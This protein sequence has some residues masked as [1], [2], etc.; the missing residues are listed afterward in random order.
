M[1]LEED[2]CFST[3]KNVLWFISKCL[4]LREQYWSVRL[5]K[6]HSGKNSPANVG[7]T[8]DA[9]SIPGSGRYPGEGNGNPLRYSCL[10]NPIDRGGWWAT[11]HGGQRE[12]DK[13][14]WLK[15]THSKL[16]GQSFTWAES[17]WTWTDVSSSHP[18]LYALPDPV[19]QDAIR[20]LSFPLLPKYINDSFFVLFLSF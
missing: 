16:L 15:Y 1:M 7:D 14:E 5:P 11:V 2:T 20:N 17:R 10:E 4:L 6:W 12:L 18:A 9:V 19:G 3:S 8:R 13:T